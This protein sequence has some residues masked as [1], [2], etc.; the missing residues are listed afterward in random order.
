V[1]GAG[2]TFLRWLTYY[3]HRIADDQHWGK[4]LSGLK[5]DEDGGFYI[6]ALHDLKFIAGNAAMQF[7]RGPMFSNMLK[8]GEVNRGHF[9]MSKFDETMKRERIFLGGAVPSVQA[10]NGRPR[11]EDTVTQGGMHGPMS[12]MVSA[13]A[14]SYHARLS[15]F[16]GR[17]LP[18]LL[19]GDVKRKLQH[20]QPFDHRAVAQKMSDGHTAEL[21]FPKEPRD[22]WGESRPWWA[23]EEPAAECS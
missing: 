10:L 16:V 11:P 7:L 6:E 23:E 20:I 13:L 8:T 12:S 14:E 22:G 21:V 1:S 5:Y 9:D 19:P 15:E 3:A 17:P 4:N 2:V 18:K